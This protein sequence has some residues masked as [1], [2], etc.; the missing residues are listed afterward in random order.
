MRHGD[1]VVGFGEVTRHKPASIAEADE[2]LD[3]LVAHLE[4]ITELDHAPAGAGLLAFGSFI[5]DPE[6]TQPSRRWS[7]RRWSSAGATVAAG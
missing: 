5:F 6:N 4:M 2:W 3:D 1:G 7:S